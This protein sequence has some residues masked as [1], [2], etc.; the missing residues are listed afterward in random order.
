MELFH[1]VRSSGHCLN[2]ILPPVISQCYDIRQ[3]AHRYV[4]PQ[5]RLCAISIRNPL[6]IIIG[7][8]IVNMYCYISTHTQTF[9]V[10]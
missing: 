10:C 7:L 9:D 8:K 4:L 2:C 5:C 3:P 6:S 1:K